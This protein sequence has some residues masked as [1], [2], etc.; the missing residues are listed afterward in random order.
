MTKEEDR[1]M[2]TDKKGAVYVSGRNIILLVV[3]FCLGLFIGIMN[4]LPIVVEKVTSR[5]QKSVLNQVDIPEL[6]SEFYGNKIDEI[7][8]D[9]QEKS[10]DIIK[11]AREKSNKIIK[12]AQEIY[13]ETQERMQFY[14]QGYVEGLRGKR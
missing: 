7:I 2:W 12:D 11:D 13:N 8:K 3:F 1:F 6:C 9:A 5:T 14:Y 4:R 10:K